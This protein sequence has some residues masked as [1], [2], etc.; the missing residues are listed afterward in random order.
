MNPGS[1]RGRLKPGRFR[2]TSTWTHR[3]LHIDGP[4]GQFYRQDESP[5][6]AKQALD[7]AMPAGQSHLNS[8]DVAQIKG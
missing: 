3:A 5:I 8:Q 4:S 1:L 6:T 7:Y 2:P